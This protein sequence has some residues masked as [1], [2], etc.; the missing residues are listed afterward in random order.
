MRIP[1][2]IAALAL[3]AGA[4]APAVAAAPAYAMASSCVVTLYD[5]E[6]SNP[7]EK[8]G[9][10]ELR[11]KVDGNWYPHNGH[12][13]MSGTNWDR[14]PEHFDDPSM[15]IRNT[16]NKS[17]EL[18]EMDPPIETGGRAS[19]TRGRTATCATTS[20]RARPSRRGAPCRPTST[21]TRSGSG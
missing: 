3:A 11:F 21:T 5:I 7:R 18:R 6:L 13:T 8:D 9:T 4:V 2:L 14:N 10:D 20:A 19:G 15:I 12:V 1:Q 17:F 16:E